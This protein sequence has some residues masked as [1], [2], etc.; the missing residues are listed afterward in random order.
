MA[1]L[2]RWACDGRAR[3]GASCRPTITMRGRAVCRKIR[4]DFDVAQWL[5]T[6]A[7]ASPQ[8]C[9]SA[10]RALAAP[11][12]RAATPQLLGRESCAIDQRLELRPHDLRM[13]ACEIRH[14]RETAVRARNH[15]LPS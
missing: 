8:S 5:K 9:R 15:I 3:M 7:R 14:L 1:T 13:H 11:G 10:G 12:F 2:H 4:P 6:S